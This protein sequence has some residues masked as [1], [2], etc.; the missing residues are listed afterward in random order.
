MPLISLYIV[1]ERTR[2]FSKFYWKDIIWYYY[3]KQNLPTIQ[4]FLDGCKNTYL[5]FSKSFKII[6]KLGLILRI[7]SVHSIVRTSLFSLFQEGLH[8]FFRTVFLS[9]FIQ[10]YKVQCV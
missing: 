1:S 7:H 10:K 4:F 9:S 6:I 8:T 2:G 3:S 5:D